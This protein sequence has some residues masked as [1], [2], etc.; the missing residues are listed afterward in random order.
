[1]LFGFLILSFGCDAQ[2]NGV[3]QDDEP[4]T[5]EPVGRISKQINSAGTGSS[6]YAIA[7]V[8]SDILNRELPSEYTV[9]VH[10]YDSTDA[11]NKN[12]M[13]GNGHLG[14]VGGILMRS[15]LDRTDVYEGF[16]P[17]VAEVVHT[18]YVFD[19]AAFM[20]VPSELA[21]Q[22]NSWADFDGVEGFF[23]PAGNVVHQQ[24]REAFS[25]LGYEFN[26]VE[27]DTAM[28]ADAMRDGTVKGVGGAATDWTL[29][30]WWQEID[31]RADIEVVNLSEEE[32]EKLHEAGQLT[33]T[34]SSNEVYTQDIAVDE[35]TAV[36]TINGYNARPDVSEEFVYEML[37]ILYENR[38]ELATLNRTLT[39]LSQD[40]IGLQVAGVSENPDMAVH[41]GLAKFLKEHDQWDD[42][43]TIAQ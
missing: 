20:T 18:L 12:V 34:R 35:I 15:M 28:A 38:E 33:G 21:D 10:P 30:P 17:Q 40:F 1:M 27:I 26:H 22:F 41:A 24:L 7:G 37:R 25:A 8:M 23:N 31:V 11:A 9:T 43:W 16:E 32:I 42:S 3:V 39:G 19:V 4:E 6:A 5:E 2:D 29:T 14:Y 13:N 36:L